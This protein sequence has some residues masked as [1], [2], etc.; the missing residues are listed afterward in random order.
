MDFLLILVITWCTIIQLKIYF[1]TN[2]QVID[3]KW[4]QIIGLEAEQIYD[5]ISNGEIEIYKV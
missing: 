4:E 2:V 3:V 1:P 5:K